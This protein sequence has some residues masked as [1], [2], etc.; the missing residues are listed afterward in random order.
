[1]FGL[2]DNRSPTEFTGPTVIVRSALPAALTAGM[3]R[4][5]WPCQWPSTRPGRRR[6]RVSCRRGDAERHP[7]PECSRCEKRR[8]T[9]GPEGAGARTACRAV[10]V[11]TWPARGDG[12]SEPVM[13]AA[14]HCRGSWSR[15]Y[16]LPAASH[17]R[18]D[19]ATLRG[20]ASPKTACSRR[21]DDPADRMLPHTPRLLRRPR[22]P[23]SRP[24]PRRG[25]WDAPGDVIRRSGSR[26]SS[27]RFSTVASGER[28]GRDGGPPNSA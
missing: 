24:W 5:A 1:M 26:A 13:T 21:R 17:V 9:P 15:A 19:S 22:G 3:C 6:P 28:A 7:P 12:D 14:R 23:R 2:Y 11:M 20:W 10:T 16:Q 18:R 4:P 25:S 27:T 8:A